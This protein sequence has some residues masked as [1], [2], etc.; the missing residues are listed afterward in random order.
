M[1]Q[2]SAHLLITG[3]AGFIGSHLCER[4]A[5]THRITIY[6][7]FKRNALRFTALMEHPNVRVIE[8]D[9]LDEAKLSAAVKGADIIVHCAAVAGIYSVGVN[10]SQTMRVNLF[11]LHTALEAAVA[12]RVRLFVDFSTSEVYGPF[13]FRGRE[14]DSLTLGPPGEKRWIYAVSKLAGEH[15][16]HAY[17]EERGL[18]LITLR[19]FN[20]YGPRQVGDGAIREMTLRALRNQPLTVYNEGTQIR[21]WC[22]IDD[23]IDALCAALEQ[24]KAVGEVFNIGNPRGTVTVVQLAEEIIRRSG[25][26]STIEFKKHPGP[27]IEIR[28]PAI[29]KAEAILGYRP[30]VSLGEGLD[31][32]IDWYRAHLEQCA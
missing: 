29:D 11:G 16:A 10:P 30:R 32:A 2:K 15:Y 13:V 20:I 26:R 23:F 3:G 14:S 8:G 21:A 7:S 22:Y 9:I 31:R 19:P 28:V 12:H 1:P 6:D 5:D 25:A 24:P 27:E 17:A 18:R 4:L